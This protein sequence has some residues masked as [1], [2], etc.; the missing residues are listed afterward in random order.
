MK[1]HQSI[2]AVVIVWM[3]IS[4]REMGKSDS[5]NHQTEFLAAP[6]ID[7]RTIL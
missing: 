2:S 4:F 5:D 1:A 7:R 6:L 3:M